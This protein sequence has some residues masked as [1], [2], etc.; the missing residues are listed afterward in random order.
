M[1]RILVVDDDPKICRNLSELLIDEG[2]DVDYVQSAEE[3]FGKV[4]KED[5]D[6]V[7][8]DLVMP[9][10]GGMDVLSY[11]KR[12]K[13]KTHVIMI[14]A[15]G[16]IENA[17]EAMKKG[18]TDYVAKP[19]KIDEIQTSIK[20]ALEEAEFDEFR[21]ERVKSASPESA[22][23]IQDVLSS[24]ANP[25]R[26]GVVELLDEQ[27]YSF[28]K[29]KDELKIE[30]PTKLSFHLR[31]LKSAGI[32]DQDYKKVYTLSTRGKRAIEVLAGLKKD[33]K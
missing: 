21:R 9:K 3:A 27:K 8:T 14:T 26:R 2:H 28:T 17:V 11:V 33:I 32:L 15:F 22:E 12:T 25:I 18:A 16:T 20:R 10:I 13:P 23:E 24:L 29:I 30:D 1:A 19:F 5:F 6:I 31:K 7:L 4:A